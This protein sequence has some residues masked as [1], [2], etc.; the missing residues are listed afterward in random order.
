M[1][2]PPI[3]SITPSTGID[4]LSWRKVAAARKLASEIRDGMIDEVDRAGKVVVKGKYRS[5]VSYL[6]RIGSE[7]KRG[8]LLKQGRLSGV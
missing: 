8:V 5:T 2:P 7:D 3:P 4:E 1:A 6:S